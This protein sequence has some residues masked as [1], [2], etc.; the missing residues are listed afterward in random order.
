VQVSENVPELVN[1]PVDCVPLVAFVPSH[2]PDAV[3]LIALVDD[4]VSAELVPLAMVCGL[5]EI[6]TV[7]AGAFTVTVAD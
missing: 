6:V 3:Q 1:A 4:Q 5:A 2:A 7:G